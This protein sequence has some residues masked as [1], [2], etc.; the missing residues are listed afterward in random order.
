MKRICKKKA[1][2]FTSVDFRSCRR[3]SP[4]TTSN[5]SFRRPFLLSSSSPSTGHSTAGRPSQLPPLKAGSERRSPQSPPRPDLAP[6]RSFATGCFLSTTLSPSATP[7]PR[8]HFQVLLLHDQCSS[9]FASRPF[10][11]IS[12]DAS[13]FPL[14]KLGL[15]FLSNALLLSPPRWLKLDSRSSQIVGRCHRSRRT[16]RPRT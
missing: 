15:L 2:P 5:N 13:F 9:R 1:G 3:L 11:Q 6:L 14:S 16:R 12:L 8:L 4:P 10:L 7:R